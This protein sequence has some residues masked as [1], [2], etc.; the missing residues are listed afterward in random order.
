MDGER[1]QI[2]RS[3]RFE[4]PDSI[5]VKYF[6]I[7]EM[8]AVNYAQRAFRRFNDDSCDY[9][10]KNRVN[11]SHLAGKFLVDRD[12]ASLLILDDGNPHSLSSGWP[13]GAR[14]DKGIPAEHL[15]ELNS[16]IIGIIEVLDEFRQAMPGPTCRQ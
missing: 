10:V 2:L 13:D 14:P 5:E 1:Q 3:G 11:S 4:N 8:D 6:G 9:I 16:N 15:D 7:S 12:T